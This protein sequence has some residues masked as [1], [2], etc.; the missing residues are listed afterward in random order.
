MQLGYIFL[1][2]L[3][4]VIHLVLIGLNTAAIPVVIYMEPWYIWAPI[5]TMLSSPLMGGTNCI[6]N[7]IEN[8]FR[9]KADM[10]EIEDRI[11][12]AFNFKQKDI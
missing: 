9:V 5:V 2:K 12:E 11:S 6:F 4:A 8:Y 10:P 1:V 3:I 7:N